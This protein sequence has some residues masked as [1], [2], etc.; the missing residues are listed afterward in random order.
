MGF[1]DLSLSNALGIMGY[2]SSNIS[3]ID[4]GNASLVQVSYT[5]KIHQ[6]TRHAVQYHKTQTVTVLC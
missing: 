4:W 2:T 3:G 1:R 5:T 6:L